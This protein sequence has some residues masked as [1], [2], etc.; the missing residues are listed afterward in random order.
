MSKLY[1]NASINKNFSLVGTAEYVSPEALNKDMSTENFGVDLWALGCIIYK[2]FEG[3]TPFEEEN[4]NKI[5]QKIHSIEELK[6]SNNTPKEAQDLIRK[7]LA[8]DPCDRIGFNDIQDLKNHSFFNEIDF[9]NIFNIDPPNDPVILAMTNK[10]DKS[11]NRNI[12]HANLSNINNKSLSSSFKDFNNSNDIDALKDA[13]TSCKELNINFNKS[14][15]NR[16]FINVIKEINNSSNSNTYKEKYLNSPSLDKNIINTIEKNNKA[17][18]SE[19]LTSINNSNLAK[20][21]SYCDYSKECLKFSISKYHK[22][23]DNRKT[24]KLKFN[25]EAIILEGKYYI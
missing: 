18:S 4:E 20:K 23:S 3:F 9:N 2:F 25:D 16:Y 24:K 13:K 11:L 12:S 19:F 17:E 6:F 15:N 5:F 7:L 1:N 8:K 14:D 22:H 10:K 21:D